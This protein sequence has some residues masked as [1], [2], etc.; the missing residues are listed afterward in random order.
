[1]VFGP[2]VTGWVNGIGN[3]AFTTKKFL[4]VNGVQL[5]L[6]LKDPTRMYDYP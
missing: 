3:G 5:G 2:N 1:M 6:S 4:V